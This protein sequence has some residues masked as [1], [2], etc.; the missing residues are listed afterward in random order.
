MVEKKNES[1]TNR[2]H[3]GVK[4]M[5]KSLAEG[6]CSRREFLRTTTLLGISAATAY[7][8][9]G[10][11]LGENILPDLISTAHAGQKKG[12]LLKFGM[13]VQE[14]ADPATYS[15][16]EKSV[17]ARHIVEYMV[18]TGPDN[19]TRPGLAESWE[20][21]DD[22][23]TWTFHLRKGV[24]WSNGDDFNAD[25]VVFNFTRWLDPKTG[26]SNLGLFNTMLEETG[27]KDKKGNAVKRMIKNAVEKVDDHTVQLNL[28]APALSIPEN[29]YNYPT[30]IVHRNFEKEG[31]DL[32]K[33]PVGTGPYALTEFKVGEKAVLKKRKE[34]YWGGEV[35]LD[36]IR[37]IDLGSDAG[38]YLAAIASKQVDALYELD[39]TTLEAAKTIPGIKVVSI[40]STQTG[41]IR[42]KVTE[43][44]FDDIR[45]RKAVQKTCDAQRQLDIAHQGLGIIGEHHHV[46][47]IHPEYF[48]LPPVKQDIAG[49]KKLLAEAGYPDGIELT[50]NVGNTNGTWEQ[51]SVAILKEDAAKAGI[52]IKMNVMPSAQ[53]WDVWTKAP[54]SLP[55]WAH[56]PL[57]V[58]VLGLAYRAG[59]PWNES[60]YDNPAFDAALTDAESTLDIEKRRA[61]MEK[62]EKIL[63]DDAVMVQPFFRSVFTAT[64]E[65]VVGFE[66]HPTRYYRFHKVSLA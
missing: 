28:N 6:K 27:E 50:C 23:K 34:P 10:T 45:V 4:E 16:T 39:L 65:N 21:S 12:G 7:A 3:P 61:K 18:E 20:A 9:A 64:L 5:E 13:V 43:K 11:I 1:S 48:K 52:N 62:V 54:L 38:A 56:R 15:W 42:M 22:L 33:N 63:Q 41:V 26:S 30:A 32:S 36:E 58:M 24:K 44:P 46:A 53:Y 66:M 19:V 17:V 60:S 35:F 25:D 47:T 29:L 59:V 37:F 8:L 2:V 55:S 49:A 40:P 57:A 14:M 51:N 31:G